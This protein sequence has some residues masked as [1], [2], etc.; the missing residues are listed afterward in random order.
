MR[1]ECDPTGDIDKILAGLVPGAPAVKQ[2]EA[3]LQSAER[4]LD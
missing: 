1:E 4:D 2:A 3:K